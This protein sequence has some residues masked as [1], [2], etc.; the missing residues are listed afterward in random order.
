MGNVCG[1]WERDSPSW[2]A[3]GSTTIKSLQ[4]RLME[5]SRFG[6]SESKPVSVMTSMKA[7]FGHWMW[8][9]MN[10]TTT[11]FNW[12]LEGMTRFFSSGRTQL[13]QSEI[14]LWRLMRMSNS[15]G[16]KSINF[17]MMASICKP[18]SWHFKTTTLNSSSTLSTELSL[19]STKTMTL[20]KLALKMENWWSQK[21]RKQFKEQMKRIWRSSLK[22][23]SKLMRTNFWT[24]CTW[25]HR[26]SRIID[27]LKFCSWLSLKQLLWRRS[28]KWRRT[29]PW[30][31]RKGRI[32]MIWPQRSHSS[33]SSLKRWR[34][35]LKNISI[36]L[37]DTFEEHISWIIWVKRKALS[38]VFV[39]YIVVFYSFFIYICIGFMN[40]WIN[41]L[42]KYIISCWNWNFIDF[43]VKKAFCH[44]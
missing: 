5:S 26:Q 6:T 9:K 25:W 16:S 38:E 14:T 37:K 7:K 41:S 13:R 4:L 1:P 35:I 2:D 20:V 19:L 29:L 23:C 28:F 44:N 21:K 40:R 34:S 10:R 12:W 15:K 36:G 22:N 27:L 33:R 31:A 43:A 32:S 18:P 17:C 42:E 39:M 11:R 24:F 8:W 30:Q 3:N